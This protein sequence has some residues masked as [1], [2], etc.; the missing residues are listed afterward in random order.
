VRA[1]ISTMSGI[2]LE[3]LT[4]EDKREALLLNETLSREVIGQRRAIDAV[5][6]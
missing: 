4:A 5:T 1:A 2:P 6:R 3:K